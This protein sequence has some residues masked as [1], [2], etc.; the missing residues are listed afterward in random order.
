VARGSRSSRLL[1]NSAA[2][3]SVA[4]RVFQV[5]TSD[6]VLGWNSSKE[7]TSRACRSV[8]SRVE[9]KKSPTALIVALIF[10]R[11]RRVQ[12]ARWPPAIRTDGNG[13]RPR[14]NTQ[15]RGVSFVQGH[16]GVPRHTLPAAASA[17]VHMPR[18]N[19]AER[20]D[21]RNPSLVFGQ[22]IQRSAL[23]EE[24][25]GRNTHHASTGRGALHAVAA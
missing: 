2:S 25:K 16:R 6:R 15:P 10:L 1:V 18:R 17:L 9:K 12:L 3:A 7:L 14:R 19:G 4:F 21:C 23:Q 5:G 24:T 13:V 8:V 11:V 20:R 22:A